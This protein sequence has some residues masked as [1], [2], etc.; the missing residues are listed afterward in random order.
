MPILRMKEIRSMSKEERGKK[1]LELQVELTKLRAMFKARGS[2]KNP[3]SIK[4]I[5]RTIARMLTVQNEDK[6]MKK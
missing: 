3:Q 1:L 4:Q 5:K 6:V 2:I